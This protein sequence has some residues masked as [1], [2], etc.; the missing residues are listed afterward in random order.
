MIPGGVADKLGNSYEAN[1]ALSKLLLV[2]Q[3]LADA[4]WF[5]PVGQNAGGFEFSL[6]LN[7]TT[8]WHQCKSRRSTGSWTMLALT[9]EG[10]LEAFARKLADPATVCIFVSS[11]P[12]K[13][14]KEIVDKAR[15]TSDE[16]SFRAALSGDQQTGLLTL[17]RVW[18]VPPDQEY[19]WLRRCRVETVSDYS[20]LENLK[21]HCGLLFRDPAQKT[22]DAL[23]GYLERNLTRRLGTAEVGHAAESELGLNWM[24]RLDPTVDQAITEATDA[25]VLS[26]NT[27]I[28][29]RT[30]ATKAGADAKAALDDPAKNILLVT[31]Q[32]GGGK[33]AIIAHTIEAAR[34]KGWHVLAFRI[35]RFLEA[36][37]LD[38]L[39]RLVIGRDEN[40]LAVL[41]NRHIADD[42]LLVIDQIDAVSDA[43]GRTPR[44]RDML[45]GIIR[46]IAHYP[47]LKLLLAC[48]S[49]DL[50]NDKSLKSLAENLTT[51][52]VAVEALS[53][54]DTVL[55]LLSDLGLSGRTFTDAE[56]RLLCVPIN[57]YLFTEIAAAGDVVGTISASRLFDQLLSVRARELAAKNVPWTPSAALGAIAR[58]MSDHQ[59]LAAPE[60]TLA[61]F[62][63]AL[64]LLSSAS[65]TTQGRGKVQF[66][67]ESFFDQVFSSHFVSEN[68]TVLELLQSAE[69]GLFRRTQVRQ[70]FARLREHGAARYIQ[71]LAEVMASD[72][73]RYLV[74]DAVGLWLADLATPTR[75]E[76]DLVLGWLV[77]DHPLTKISRM[78]LLGQGWFELL[79]TTGTLG[80]WLEAGEEKHNLALWSLRGSAVTSPDL[81]A[82]VLRQWWTRHPERATDLITWF[83]NLYVEG[84]MGSLEDLYGELIAAA[85]ATMFA[86]D[87]LPEQLDL[88]S[89][90]H[91]D[92]ERGARVLGH[93]LRR[94]FALNPKGEPF[95]RRMVQR[96]LHSLG[97]ITEKAPA[98]FLDNVLPFFSLA[99]ERDREALAVGDIHYSNFSLIYDDGDFSLPTYTS[100]MARAL[101]TTAEATPEHAALLLDG[102]PPTTP[103]AVHLHL[104]A[105]A[106]N[107]AALA[108]RLVPLLAN[109]LLL[110]AGHEG[111]TWRSFAA[112]AHAAMAHLGKAE[113]LTV[114][115]VVFAHR[116]EYEFA[117]KW[118]RRAAAGDART[119]E[120]AR[121]AVDRLNNAGVAERGIWH[122]IG[123]DFLSAEALR[124][125]AEL[126]RK[127]PGAPLPEA[128]MIQAG[129]VKSPIP[130]EAAA[131][132]SDA[133]WLR[134]MEH[135]SEGRAQRQWPTF[136]IGGC[137]QLASVLREQTKQNPERFVGLLG[138]MPLTV[139]PAYPD[140]V[141][142]GLQEAELTPAQSCTVAELALR[143]P[144]GSFD[145]AFCWFLQRHTAATRTPGALELLMQIAREGEASDTHVSSS[146][147]TPD[148]ERSM[149]EL[150]GRGGDFEASGINGERGAAFEALAN[151]LWAYEDFLAP[152]LSFAAERIAAEPLTS[153]RMPMLH[154]INSVGKYDADQCIT[155]LLGLG[156]RDLRALC[157]SSGSHLMRWA[158]YNYPERLRSLVDDLVVAADFRVRAFGLFL[159]SGI[160]LSDDQAEKDLFA[161]A[162]ARLTRQVI[163]FRASGN[164]GHDALA[165]RAA[166]WLR[167]LFDDP[168]ADV[169]TESSH[170]PWDTLLDQPGDESN[171]VDAYIRSRA[172][173]EHLERF[174][175]AVG[176]RI[177]QRRDLAL[178]AV[179]RVVDEVRRQQEAGERA[180]GLYLHRL[181]AMLVNL[182]RAF[183]GEVEK[184]RRILDL[185]DEYLARDVYDMRK[186]IAD[187]ERH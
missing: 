88:G 123:R 98:A 7:G 121:L 141:L 133:H 143:W 173:G 94:W 146:K 56:Q 86:E 29:G 93:W 177:D 134:A 149:R 113:R 63:G 138:R 18:K 62:S 108:H 9:T 95:E 92:P 167:P 72:T 90:S 47:K 76:L 152:L 109:P 119:S 154:L 186:A 51:Q 73:V 24:A 45:L 106:A 11:D 50:A 17:R 179:G 14:F 104:Q 176:E 54:A 78:V 124:R 101:R 80:T 25:Y 36:A 96:D 153:V 97:Y 30:L 131:R 20:V 142:M 81:A 174:M 107:G 114:E 44:V 85:P 28:A 157:C 12:A 163:A 155:L 122:T 135:Y 21:A 34:A 150:I 102:L 70:I 10:V 187:F 170:C 26:L 111:A 136:G 118:L 31:G 84:P 151:A 181:G 67:H 100:L 165:E 13:P 178:F 147:T 126:D 43:S 23:R 65:L 132:M 117:L 52:V 110:K 99:L 71:N 139:N 49:Y 103:T 120:Q 144:G 15:L 38:D 6:S 161:L 166:R 130:A 33:S 168:D 83:N 48:R 105:I 182:Y 158:C 125:W 5:E 184:E 145:R 148:D 39:G 162:S 159:L 156:R 116:P 82:S 87:G 40:P 79:A 59:E 41:G 74:K 77:P 115:R 127:F 64:D 129:W 183:E 58:W 128:R 57:L 22:V 89:W 137:E 55:P 2:L 19:A 171:V 164:L 75:R 112:A 60:A 1:W 169:R 32:A 8:E 185:F 46:G 175:M 4:L 66:A 160:A 91:R 68:R 53:W 3:G 16:K 37:T 140:A 42:T 172:F 35:D 61:A 180:R 69:Q 27:Q